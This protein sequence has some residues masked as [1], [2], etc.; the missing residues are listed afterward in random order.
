MTLEEI[1]KNSEHWYNKYKE[2]EKENKLLGERC[3]Q[4]LKDKGDLTDK[5]ADIKANCDF[6]LEGKDVEIME[7]KERNAELKEHHKKVCEEL[8]NTHRNLREQ[9]EKMKCCTN[10][11][12]YAKTYELCCYSLGD[13]DYDCRLRK[14]ELKE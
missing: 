10:C 3:N 9:I 7:L 14:W 5:I 2:L 4:L 13:E 1:Q 12:H 8:T 6:A 11:K